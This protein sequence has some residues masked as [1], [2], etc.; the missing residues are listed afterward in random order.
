MFRFVSQKNKNEPRNYQYH[1]L[2]RI[3]LHR[4]EFRAERHQK[5]QN[6]KPCWLYLFCDLWCFQRLP[7]ANHYSK[8][9]SLFCAAISFGQKGVN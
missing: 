1:R 3:F 4:P 8:R 7:L 9:N 6:R 2:R 5:D